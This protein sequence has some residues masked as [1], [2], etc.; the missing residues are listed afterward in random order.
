MSEPIYS[1]ITERLWQ[2]LPEVYRTYDEDNDWAFK[3][4]ISAIA[5]QLNDVEELVARF[6]LIEEEDYRELTEDID[7]TEA[8]ER[9]VGLED[10][11]SLLGYAPLYTTSDLVDSRTANVEWLPYIAQLYGVTLPN[12]TIEYQRAAIFYGYSSLRGGSK[13]ALRQ[14]IQDQLTGEKWVDIYEQRDGAGG[15]IDSPSDEWNILVVTRDEE[16]PD[17]LDIVAEIERRNAKPV[18]VIV[19]AI[20][21]NAPWSLIDTLDWDDIEAFSTWNDLERYQP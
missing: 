11:E 14:A 1:P 13:L 7:V 5:D 2:R 16:T 4:Y 10:E 20:T 8:F 21:Y 6:T 19:N 3:K 9:P 12:D 15:S 17:G 18:G